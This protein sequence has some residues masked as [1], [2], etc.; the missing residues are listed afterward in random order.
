VRAILPPHGLLKLSHLDIWAGRLYK[1]DHISTIIGNHPGT[2]PQFNV[3][4]SPAIVRST[5][6][7]GVCILAAPRARVGHQSWPN[8]QSGDDV[9]HHRPDH[10][11]QLWIHRDFEI[12]SIRLAYYLEQQI[13]SQ[14]SDSDNVRKGRSA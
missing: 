9:W 6:F 12:N 14:G 10:R 5:W 2:H 3:L 7:I 11:A 4:S 1:L 13:F 8:L